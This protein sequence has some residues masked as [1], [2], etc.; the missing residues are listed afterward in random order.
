MK[1]VYQSARKEA[2]VPPTGALF[3]NI[4]GGFE[5]YY[6]KSWLGWHMARSIMEISVL[7]VKF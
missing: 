7:T 1:D 2:V 4:P 3:Y 6:E 5:E